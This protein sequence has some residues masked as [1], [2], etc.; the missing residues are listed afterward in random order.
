MIARQISRTLREGCRPPDASASGRLTFPPFAR[1][2]FKLNF[3]V[4]MVSRSNV[5]TSTRGSARTSLIMLQLPCRSGLLLLVHEVEV[6]PVSFHEAGGAR[7]SNRGLAI[8]KVFVGHRGRNPL[9]DTVWI[10]DEMA[11]DGKCSGLPVRTLNAEY[12]QAGRRILALSNV[13]AGQRRRP[14]SRQPAQELDH[15]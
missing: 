10:S 9:E 11:T 2:Q 3:P 15:G 12:G 8:P 13:V 5:P 14:S 7:S 1:T 6:G 4:S